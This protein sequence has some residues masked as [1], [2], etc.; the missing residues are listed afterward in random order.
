MIR[1]G[2]VFTERAQE[3]SHIVTPRVA[4][5]IKFL[6]GISVC[7][8]VVTPKWVEESGRRGSFLPEEDYL[9]RDPDAEQLFGMNLVQSL[10]RARERKLMGGLG[11]YATPSVQPPPNALGEIVRCAGGELLSL[12]QVRSILSSGGGGGGGAQGGGGVAT[13]GVVVLSTPADI[14]NGCCTEFTMRNISKWTLAVW[15]CLL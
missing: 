12:A 1:L 14:G 8:C 11:V 5:T 9:L 2:G 3:C 7:D 15:P 4:R 13:E 10:V 6:A